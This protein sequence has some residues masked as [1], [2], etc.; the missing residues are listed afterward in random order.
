MSLGR[1]SSLPFARPNS[2]AAG[3]RCIGS[4]VG[5]L[6]IAIA[7]SLVVACAGDGTPRASGRVAQKTSDGLLLAKST[8]RSVLWVKPDHHLGRY[9][10]V[11]VQV[12]GFLYADGQRPLERDQ[13]QEVG[14]ILAGALAG[15]TASGPVGVARV[16]G[17]CTV[18]VNVG[19][20]DL[21]LHTAGNDA[22]GSSTSYV[23]S[24]GSAT[25][26]VEFRDSMTD[27]PLLRYM[28]ARGLGGGPGT[29]QSGANLA[30]LG[31]TLGEIV[32]GMVDELA[33]IVPST[34]AKRQH[35]CKDGIYALTGRG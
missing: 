18:V 3:A 26:V 32:T 6:G 22:S 23:S 29:G 30:R 13:E 5:A 14:R 33:K 15:I 27:T 8:S 12:A 2:K 35:E 25:L 24:F 19:L 9:D 7:A 4:R 34:T 20:K 10:D 16:P 21:R 31:E 28:A 1:R 11:I 17:P